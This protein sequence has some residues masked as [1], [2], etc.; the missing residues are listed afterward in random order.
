MQKKKKRNLIKLKKKKKRVNLFF[1]QGVHVC[2]QDHYVQIILEN[3][4]LNI[5]NGYKIYFFVKMV[6]YNTIN[7][8]KGTFV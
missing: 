3:S 6:F 2:I 4:K 5:I 8:Y 7:G 1:S